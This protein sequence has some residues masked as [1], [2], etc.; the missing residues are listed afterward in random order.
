MVDRGDA[1]VETKE[2]TS[3]LSDRAMKVSANDGK[4]MLS[5]GES[6][7]FS[8]TLGDDVVKA[9]TWS[10]DGVGSI[11]AEGVYTAPSEIKAAGDRV[12]ITAASNDG[13]RNIGSLKIS[14]RP[15]EK[16]ELPTR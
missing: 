7:T 1:K 2:A 16:P 15:R 8:A 12:T 6:A 14:L 3:P 10:V 9:V 5:E 11:S 4:T 13:S